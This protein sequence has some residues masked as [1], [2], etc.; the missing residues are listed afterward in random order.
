MIKLILLLLFKSS[1][2]VRNV[3][4]SDIY[5]VIDEQG[6]KRI[7]KIYASINHF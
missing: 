5:R 2:L 4:S 3:L 1:G 7:S 6:L